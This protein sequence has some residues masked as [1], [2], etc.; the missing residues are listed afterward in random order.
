MKQDWMDS[1]LSAFRNLPMALLCNQSVMGTDGLPLSYE[2]FMAGFPL[3]KLF[4]PEHG[5]SAQSP[6]GQAL[7]D[8]QDAYTGLPL[9][10]LYGGRLKPLMQDMHDVEVVIADLPNIG[11][12]FY[13]YWWTITLLMEACAEAGKEFILIDRPNLSG[14]S[15]EAAEGPLLD[16]EHCASFLGRWRMPLTFHE[17]Y[18]GLLRHFAP[19]R[20]KQLD[21]SIIEFP[22]NEP[23]SPAFIPP[24]PGIP[25]RETII[26][27]PF[28]ALFEGL[29]LNN[30]RGTSYPFFVLG[31]PWINAMEFYEAFM[32]L[33]LPGI[34]AIP[35]S[36]VPAW[37]RFSGV[38]CEG[39]FFIVTDQRAF[40]PVFTGIRVM[41][42]LSLVY[43]E[44]LQEAAYPT[45]ANQTGQE[46][47]DRL[48]GIT[49]AFEKC[50]SGNIISPKEVLSLCS[51]AAW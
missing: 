18:G 50:C 48:L 21:Y 34:R 51:P 3:R 26:I 33:E 4:T 36:Y 15:G 43:K 11:C 20:L 41:N 19:Q 40:R 24:S 1:P 28:T 25:T 44:Y 12:R 9:I 45:H 8:G 7:A 16:E 37:S 13:T 35:H 5:M 27:Y 10:S 46:H 31:A 2:L 30:G 39:L 6:D 14:R 22:H 17:T 23:G 32:T 29:N 47:L 49:G 38:K 42:L